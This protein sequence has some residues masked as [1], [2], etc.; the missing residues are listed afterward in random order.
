[1]RTLYALRTYI[2]EFYIDLCIKWEVKI[3]FFLIR[4]YCFTASFIT[5]SLQSHL[6]IN[7]VFIHRY[8]FGDLKI[9]FGRVDIL[10]IFGAYRWTWYT[11]LFILVFKHFV[12]FI[13]F[14]SFSTQILFLFVLR[15]LNIGVIFNH[16][17]Y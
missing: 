1:M 3:Q 8:F 4:I 14:L 7:H 6:C 15:Y 10:T 5:Y 17:I 12:S 11:F 9:M 16:V 2:L 13:I